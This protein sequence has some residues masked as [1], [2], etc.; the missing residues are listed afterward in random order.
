MLTLMK[1][2]FKKTWTLKAILLVLT[3]IME[4]FFLYGT[5]ADQEPVMK[6]SPEIPITG[7]TE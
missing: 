3:L 5:Y 7:I 2:E 1:Y 4:I 6:A